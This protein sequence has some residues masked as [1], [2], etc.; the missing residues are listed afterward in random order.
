MFFF[1]QAREDLRRIDPTGAIAS[2]DSSIKGFV[3]HRNDVTLM[4]CDLAHVECDQEI[5]AW[6]HGRLGAFTDTA[7]RRTL[8]QK[9][10]TGFGTRFSYDKQD[11]S[12]TVEVDPIG[13]FSFYALF[14]ENGVLFSDR[15]DRLISFK[16]VAKHINPEWV[17]DILISGFPH[18]NTCI[19]RPFE[20]LAANSRIQGKG[21]RLL[22][23]SVASIAEGIGDPLPPQEVV[24]QTR[25]TLET[26]CSDYA[27]PDLGLQLTGGYDSRLLLATLLRL[28]IRPKTYTFGAGDNYNGQL[29]NNLATALNLDHRFISLGDAF[30]Q[31]FHS[32]YRQALLSTDGLASPSH[33]HYSFA[34]EAVAN[35][36]RNAVSGVAGG[37]L[38]RGFLEQNV[39]LPWLLFELLLNNPIS[40]MPGWF[41]DAI[42]RFDPQFKSTIRE[43]VEALR[44]KWQAQH[45]VDVLLRNVFGSFFQSLMRIENIFLPVSYP[46]LDIRFLKTILRS[47][48]GVLHG[49]N[50]YA[51]HLE[52]IQ[53]QRN[54]IQAYKPTDCI[55][56]ETPTDKGFPPS[57]LLNRFLWPVVPICVYR[58]RKKRKSLNELKYSTWLWSFIDNHETPLIDHAGDFHNLLSVIQN[59]GMM[60]ERDKFLLSRIIHVASA[61]KLLSALS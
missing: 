47:P 5:R 10:W 42:E 56:L 14:H 23:R 35:S 30:E 37:E 2:L 26:I 43:R 41:Q 34:S 12:W 9:E 15:L 17:A 29:A 44:A 13:A 57:Y 61:R 51:G 8:E 39:T 18:D 4:A 53:S 60:D 28:G 32:K 11:G 6:F 58:S 19:V 52:K 36:I 40:A 16:C 31:R 55:L 59:N 54:L 7:V 25:E 45:R 1:I 38:H 3:R 33:T 48:F 50:V 49:K 46:F 24:R 21:G 22:V 27:T 20:K